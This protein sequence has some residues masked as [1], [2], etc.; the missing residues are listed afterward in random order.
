MRGKRHETRLGSFRN[1]AG[2]TL[3]EVLIATTL[4][5]VMM[6][7]LLGSLRIGV[8]SWD[9]G[10]DKL[11]RASRLFLVE[12]F[13]RSH[14]GG[15]LP[16]VDME[17]PQGVGT[18]LRG[19]ENWIEYVATMPQQ[20]RMGGLYRFRLYVAENGNHYDLKVAMRPYVSNPNS[21]ASAAPAE[22]IEDVVLLEN[23]AG[24]KFSY[25]PE[26]LQGAQTVGEG[27][28][29]EWQQPQLPLL[30]QVQIEPEDEEPWPAL[31]VAL[32]TRR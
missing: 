12:N 31:V 27:W 16:L 28:V 6:L 1:N 20:V 15:A 8:N 5:G 18:S 21:I 29:S 10:E 19:G 17:D 11:A 2:F 25:L 7:L 24:I 30:I 14:I 3:I 13:L 23:L 26:S 9:S 4:L 32:K 22:A